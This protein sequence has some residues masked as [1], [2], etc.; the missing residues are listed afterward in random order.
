MAVNLTYSSLVTKIK[1]YLE[2]S[3]AET[4][5]QI[6]MFIMLAIRRVSKECKT[7][8]LKEFVYAEFTAG[9]WIYAK[10]GNWR[11]VSTITA[12]DIKPP[13]NA[14]HPEFGKKFPLRVVS[15]SYLERFA[16]DVTTQAKPQ[17]YSDYD[18]DH[19]YIAPTPDFAY[20][21]QIGFYQNELQIDEQQQTNFLISNA[22]ELIFY[23]SMLEAQ[24][25]IKNK[26]AWREMWQPMYTEALQKFN[27][28]D[29][30]RMFD[31]YSRRDME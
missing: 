2:R 30:M 23:A 14:N 5:E 8:G 21:I 6:P 31:S 15:F 3:D 25:Y 27:L 9:V 29:A 18:Y 26:E 4:V 28:E 12:V 17:F 20:P 16:P 11:N 24:P 1:Q 7:L 13:Q 19:W 10:P 22:P